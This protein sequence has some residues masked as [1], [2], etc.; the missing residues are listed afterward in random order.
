MTKWDMNWRT[1]PVFLLAVSA[2]VS[3]S[4]AGIATGMI[5]AA[6]CLSAIRERGAAR[7]PARPVL[8]SLGAL[9]GSYL[10]ATLLAGPHTH[11]WN[12]FGEELWIKLLLVTIPLLASR[13]PDTLERILKA[14]LVLGAV[15]AGY[16][17]VQH[18]LGVDPIRGRSLFRPQFGHYAVSG[19]FSHHLSYAGQALIFLVMTAAWCLDR[20][21]GR[22]NLWLV[23]VLAVIGAALM[24][25]FAR[26]TLIGAL[27]GLLVLLAF[28]PGRVRWWSLF[29]ILLSL[30]LVMAI[31]PVRI[32]LLQTFEL[33][34]H[35]TRLN[36]WQSSWEGIKAN[37]LLGFG[38]G[39]FEALLAEHQVPGHY[40]TLA[41][42]HSDLLMHGVNAGIPGI[43][44][45][46]ALLGTTCW[47]VLRAR[48][49][50]PRY[51]WV[52]S[53]AFSVQVGI[54]VAG[55]FQ[56]FQTDDEVEMLLYFVLGCALA[57]A[58]KANPSGSP[59]KS[60]V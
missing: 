49:S 2:A 36:L 6:A 5:L 58:G 28:L 37:P 27:C 41:H 30:V 32:H 45:A 3:V 17:V 29:G 33:D 11:H 46:V 22:R 10:L 43:L 18:F 50:Q 44:A 19:F 4:V 15:T 53:G 51:S 39:N 35:L 40:E 14:A 9:V 23:P 20:P 38:P 34:R 42:S 25:T 31:T 26:S 21:D 24:W 47:V 54:T 13:H 1:V 57:L 52:F 16:A 59:E 12:K 48:K 56:V 60:G 8:L 55:F 7:W